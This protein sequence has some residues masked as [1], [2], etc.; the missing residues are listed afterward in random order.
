M[1]QVKL[2]PGTNNETVFTVSDYIGN[3]FEKTHTGI[4]T[5][6]IPI[7]YDTDLENRVFDEM[8]LVEDGDLLFR[9][10][11]LAVESDEERAQTTISGKG[12]TWDLTNDERTVTY[13]DTL[14]HKAIED[15][16]TTYTNFDA[17]VITPT[18]N[19]QVTDQTVQEGDTNTELENITSL[20]DTDPVT[21]SG[22]SIKILQTSFTKEGEA[23]DDQI[24]SAFKNDSAYSDG[25]AAIL[26]STNPQSYSYDFTLDYS[27][28]AADFG[29]GVRW[30]ATGTQTPELRWELDGEEVSTF[31]PDTNG[32]TWEANIIEAEGNQPS[33]DVS[34][35]SHTLS[36]E[37]V[38]QGT[39]SFYLDVVQPYD[40]GAR[41]SFGPFNYTYDDTVDGNGYLEGPE[42]F[43]Q[44][45]ELEFNSVTTALNITEADLL[46]SWD[47]IS[48]GQAIQLRLGSGSYLPNDGSEQNT[49]S[50]T[51]DFGGSAGRTITAKATF[52]R[53]GTQTTTPTTGIN[54][55]T[56]NSLE[57][58]I[59]GN[60]LVV[61]ADRTFEGSDFEILQRMHSLG[62]MRFSVDH[63]PNSKPITSFQVG[64]ATKTLPDIDVKN[65]IT[66]TDIDN[67]GNHVTVRGQRVGGTRLTA[68]E[69]DSQDINEFGKIH[70]D[71]VD[72][73]LETQIAVNEAAKAFLE[74]SLREL[75]DK[76]TLEI[77]PQDIQPGFT[78]DVPFSDE[79]VPLEEVRYQESAGQF[80]GQL[81]FD[82]R[83]ERISEFISGLRGGVNNTKRGF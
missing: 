75:T 73:D 80:R 46:T 11:V 40:T 67:Y 36:V 25:S 62:D 3:R 37:V 14:A 22:D 71:R 16:L 48:N 42:F 68:T 60:D 58:R 44:A 43:P 10:T 24:N 26:G 38:S 13:V 65:R 20:A 23:F 31:A 29:V 52:S 19:V 1:A 15:F 82:F 83:A 64:D 34:A 7:G 51:T 17:T 27:I 54:G 81:I 66:K 39:E 74:D 6:N 45:F 59:D 56:I 35:G 47:D 70:K 32:P 41:Y 4:G 55:Q 8:H 72:P 57:I 30:D 61:F 9:G 5:F 53:Y 12:V 21:I 49:E 63:Q 18:P 69:S 33:S 76:A 2:S 50:I 79:D 28:P 77:A 78:Y